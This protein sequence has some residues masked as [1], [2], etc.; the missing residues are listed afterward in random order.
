MREDVINST[1]FS[2]EQEA[3]LE[4]L[5]AQEGIQSSPTQ[6]IK[7]RAAGE[8]P[9]LS[10]AQQ[11]L[12]FLD[13][14]IP[15]SALYTLPAAF[16][17]QGK[18]DREAFALALHEIVRRHETLRT[19]FVFVDGKPIQ[20]IAET[21]QQALTVMDLQAIPAVERTAE[22]QRLI[23]EEIRKP[24]NLTSDALLRTILLQLGAT[25]YIF[26]LTT[27]HIIS[28]TWSE[29]LFIQELSSLYMAFVQGKPSTLP[30]LPIQYADFT[31][32]QRDYLQGEVHNELI[33]Y[34]KQQLENVSPLELP[35]DR[36][37]P[38]DPSYK[39]AQ[40]SWD[41]PAV[42]VQG[43]KA[44]GKQ[45]NV[46]L[47][48]TLLAAFQTLLARY[49]GQ[50]DIAV[51]SPIANRTLT[52]LESL[53]GFF[54]NT[55]V[56]RT[57][58]SGNP[59]FRTLLD[60]V[61]ET[62]LDAY[63]HQDLPFEQLVE[64]LR[65]PRDPSRNPLFQVM[66]NMQN[67]PHTQFDL[68]GLTLQALPID[69]KIA[70]FDLILFVEEDENNLH[71]LAE[72]S[73]DLFE[74]A[75]VRRLLGHY[76]TLLEGIVEDPSRSLASLPLL[77]PTE[78]EQLLVSWNDTATSFPPERCVHHLIEDQV[79]RTPALPALIAPGGEPLSYRQLN[80]RANQLAHHLIALGVEPGMRVG[81]YLPR[82]LDAFVALLA[83][84]KAGAAYVPIDPANPRER[85]AF[86]MHDAQIATLLTHAS[87]LA[88]LPEHQAQTLC[89]DR[90]WSIIATAS[91]TNPHTSV[92][93]AHLLY[94]M[95]TSGST[96]KPKSVAMSHR[97]LQNLLH[98]Q[99]STM[100]PPRAA[101]MLQ[102][103][104]LSFDVSFQEIFPTLSAGGTI[105]LI[106]E[107]LRRD[108]LALLRLISAQA[109]QKLYL[110]VVA[111]QQLADVSTMEDLDLSELREITAAGE[112][113]QI[114]P[115]VVR[116]FQRAS[117]CTLHNFYG[118]TETHGV[119]IFT[120][121]G[122]PATWPSLVPIGKPIANDQ[123]Y[124]LDP[125]GSP[126]P[127]GITGELY[128]GGIGVADGY[129]N[130]PELSAERF[131]P[132]PYGPHHGARLYKSGDLARYRPD[133]N[134]EFLGRI[135]HQVKLRGFRVELE[136]I[137]AALNQHPA[138]RE[139]VVIVRE[140]VPGDK[141]L[142]AYLVT[143]DQQPLN[144]RELRA[145]VLA[146]LPDYMIPGSY[147]FLDAFPLTINRK[148]DQR[149]LPPP[150]Q[151]RP[152]LEEHFVAP[153]TTTEQQLA[154]IWQEIL[155]LERVGVQ[156]NFFELG[157]HSLLITQV[158]SRI[159]D[160][161]G[162]NLPVRSFFGAST[163]AQ[164]AERIDQTQKNSRATDTDTSASTILR[165][166]RQRVRAQVSKQGELTVTQTHQQ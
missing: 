115:Q 97:A 123:V 64:E 124:V 139:S 96:G 25:E 160:I 109:I 102:F 121:Q 146:S 42:L 85:T 26:L 49:S 81:I 162:V 166:S 35:S 154:Q 15:D 12:W 104:S 95:Y 126:L 113:L 119:T 57:D 88:T 76:Q 11:R 2:I 48:M 151:E 30:A 135:D 111:L 137:E 54:A 150:D 60:R 108:P 103:A 155:R 72:Y 21:R 32:W 67:T 24:F 128:L 163:I 116:F 63:A 71:I 83:I 127:I 27:H 144:T 158:V 90:D 161:F 46:T 120:L 79:Q 134:L 40:I 93:P 147:I 78:R 75:T 6:T 112:Q 133:G 100:V 3:L 77:T 129:L 153:R 50:E 132:D 92:Q 80:E 58:L 7:R 74:E 156:D 1:D 52:E 61:R 37:R 149:R 145:S 43:L 69:N 47:F 70:P 164:I 138:V 4:L 28:D 56:L 106:T 136:E 9:P 130:R 33:Q 22:V 165:A 51:G 110:P 87:L 68:P 18:L 59:S 99:L 152:A 41:L 117:N 23:Q 122:D 84:L 66:F 141:R 140:D 55:L 45:E 5:L 91:T 34:W 38:T 148:V 65:V 16:K 105:F 8:V 14:L 94:A 73:T 36:P 44:V 13:Q 143:Q 157:G 98:W 159:R 39:G 86:M 118:P 10:F 107:E 101:R 62:L 142:V 125:A 19:N 89:L 114:T 131:V 31:R 82:S 53:I 20:K 17:L 29:N